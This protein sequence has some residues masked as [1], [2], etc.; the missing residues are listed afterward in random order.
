MP[1][2]PGRAWKNL[3]RVSVLVTIAHVTMV[4]VYAFATRAQTRYLANRPTR[5]NS[6]RFLRVITPIRRGG[7]RFT[8]FFFVLVRVVELR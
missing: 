1:R 7:L 2:N 5:D 8:I 6:P 3:P 4:H